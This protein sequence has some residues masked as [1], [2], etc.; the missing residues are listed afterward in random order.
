M[1]GYVFPIAS[2]CTVTLLL[3]FQ[4]LARQPIAIE[5]KTKRHHNQHAL[6]MVGGSFSRVPK[7]CDDHRANESKRNV[8]VMSICCCCLFVVVISNFELFIFSDNENENEI[9]F[10]PNPNERNNE[11]ENGISFT[12]NPNERL[13]FTTSHKNK[14]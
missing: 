9:S 14:Q 11:N 4:D 12:P 5:K 6:A 7:K 8:I 1:W 2:V 10:T 13:N 3:Y